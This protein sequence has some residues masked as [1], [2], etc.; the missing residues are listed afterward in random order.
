ML[1]TTLYALLTIDVLAVIANCYVLFAHS[2]DNHSSIPTGPSGDHGVWEYD[3][4]FGE[5][6]FF[7]SK[8]NRGR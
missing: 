7:R 5:Y 2:R 8:P 6:H 3:E 1:E 4:E